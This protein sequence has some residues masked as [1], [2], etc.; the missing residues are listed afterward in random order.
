M[1]TIQLKLTAIR[2]SLAFSHSFCFNRLGMGNHNLQKLATFLNF[3][4]K[5]LQSDHL[6][7]I[8]NLANK[9]LRLNAIV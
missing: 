6:T 4:Q 8:Y 9:K 7:G 3:S 1:H 5:G 2:T